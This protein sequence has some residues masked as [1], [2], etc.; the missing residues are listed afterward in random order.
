MR[1]SDMD[2]NIYLIPPNIPCEKCGV[3][4]KIL[5]LLLTAVCPVCKTEQKKENYG[6]YFGV[7][8]GVK[9]D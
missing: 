7:I 4:I 2:S 3:K 1:Y 8:K 5:E 6:K 9:N